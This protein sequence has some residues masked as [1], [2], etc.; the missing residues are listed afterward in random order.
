MATHPENFLRMAPPALEKDRYL[1]FLL[2][3]KAQ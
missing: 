2:P 3:E 1:S